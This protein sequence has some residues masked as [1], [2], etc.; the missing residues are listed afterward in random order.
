MPF[1]SEDGVVDE[2][3]YFE[4]LAQSIASVPPCPE[5]IETRHGFWSYVP[6]RYVCVSSLVISSDKMI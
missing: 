5:W 1:V 6:D 2:V 3:A 4:I